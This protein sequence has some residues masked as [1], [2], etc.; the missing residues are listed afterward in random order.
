MSWLCDNYL[1]EKYYAQ[2][3]AEMHTVTIPR[4]RQRWIM[5]IPNQATDT[6]ENSMPLEESKI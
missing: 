4:D 3:M 6:K 1:V 5:C 2:E